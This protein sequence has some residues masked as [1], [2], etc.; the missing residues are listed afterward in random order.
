MIHLA[1]RDAGLPDG[2]LFSA[3]QYRRKTRDTDGDG[4]PFLIQ[5]PS[6][7]VIEAKSPSEDLRNVSGTEQVERYWRRYGAVLLTN[8]RAFALIGKG[9]K[10]N[11]HIRSTHGQ[12]PQPDAR[13]GPEVN[14]DKRLRPAVRRSIARVAW[15]GIMILP[16]VLAGCGGD[17][18]DSVDV[19]TGD[20]VR[21]WQSAVLIDNEAGA[22]Q[23]AEIAFDANG[24]AIAVWRQFTDQ[25]GSGS[26]FL[27]YASRYVAGGGW[28]TP[29]LLNDTANNGYDPQI[30]FDSNG[31]AWVVFE[32]EH[33]SGGRRQIGAYR[34]DAGTDAW[35]ATFFPGPLED[36]LWPRIAFDDGGNAIAVWQNRDPGLWNIE[37]SF[38]TAAGSFAGAVVIDGSAQDA[39]G[40]Q[41]GFDPVG[42]AI[43]VWSQT[44]VWAN[45][46]IAGVG[47]GAPVQIE[48]NPGG[49]SSPQIAVAASGNAT[50]VWEQSGVVGNDVWANHY[51]VGSNMWSA[52][53]LLETNDTA[54]A[55]NPQ[56]A[57]DA[58]GNAM[59][60]WRQSDGARDNIF[61]NRYVAGGGWQGPTL[62][63]SNSGNAGDPS[64]AMDVNGNTSA[65][66]AQ[67]DG[68]V[69][70][71][72]DNRYTI[73]GG[74]GKAASIEGMAGTANTPR[75]ALDSNGNGFAIWDQGSDIWVNRFQP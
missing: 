68:S 1:N 42:N 59:V 22:A 46:Y 33:G 70:G 43:V 41:V 37:A 8:F 52:P 47:W 51:D 23:S 54:T 44:A 7:G 71:V 50:V 53:V 12:R 26:Y 28:G 67:S 58:A 16:L 15:C 32:V 3:D 13:K 21:P 11:V 29:R 60:V 66:W 18:G 6:R 57:C 55:L 40:P 48:S 19:G 20:A 39:Y 2:G 73:G 17:G 24:N 72:Y 75:I 62:I 27:I 64:V 45:R 31:N 65:V 5:N 61:A 63:G 30:A 74:W 49:A 35:S 36:H 10:G 34:Y 25:L 9:P 4:N 14:G 69:D 38:Y 56:I